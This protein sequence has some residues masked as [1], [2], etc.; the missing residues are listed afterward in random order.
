MIFYFLTFF[1]KITAL[2]FFYLFSIRIIIN[3]SDDKIT[4]LS[5]DISRTILLVIIFVLIYATN[6]FSKKIEYFNKN[7]FIIFWSIISLF[8]ICL[9][10][11][12]YKMDYLY[13]SNSLYDLLY[14]FPFYGL[15]SDIY[16]TYKKKLI[17]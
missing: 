13:F 14:V 9:V 7:Q 17:I 6:Y 15:I 2:Y 5:D 8:Y 10:F 4:S 3:V 16:G 12:F 11:Y 1:T